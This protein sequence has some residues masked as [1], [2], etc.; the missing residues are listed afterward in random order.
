MRALTVGMAVAAAKHFADKIAAAVVL[1]ALAF[2]VL[3]AQAGPLEDGV[4]A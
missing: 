1:A 3:S 2:V 4:A